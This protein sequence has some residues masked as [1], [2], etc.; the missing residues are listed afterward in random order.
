MVYDYLLSSHS[1]LL[2]NYTTSLKKSYDE[3]FL[4]FLCYLDSIPFTCIFNKKSLNI[5]TKKFFHANTSLRQSLNS[6][7]YPLKPLNKSKTAADMG[8]QFHIFWDTRKSRRLLKAVL[9]ENFKTPSQTDVM[10]KSLKIV[11]E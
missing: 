4:T 6:I 7:L 10:K 5:Y 1:S 8:S 3:Q 9:A 2:C 11:K